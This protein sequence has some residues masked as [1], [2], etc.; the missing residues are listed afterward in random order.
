MED[1]LDLYEEPHDPQLPTVCFDELPYQL[2]DEVRLPL[3]AEPGKPQRYD[4]EYHRRGTCN[5]FLH[6]E[7]QGGWRHVEVTERRTAQDFAHQMKALTEVHYPD[8][9]KIRVVLDNLS[10][11]TPAALYEAFAPEEARRILRRLEFHYT[12]KHG[13]WLNM[14]EIELS[15]LSRQCLNRRLGTKDVVRQE[16][17]AWEEPRN[18]AGVTIQ[19]RFTTDKAREKLK[20]LYPS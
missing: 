8:A 16:V 1:L 15:V 9:R 7:P 5:V 18:Q 14:A 2:T 3:P 11:H 6:L 10:T 4:Y 20:R 17:A 19:W 13:S 12:P